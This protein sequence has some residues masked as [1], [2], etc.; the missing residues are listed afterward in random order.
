M[1]YVL[2]SRKTP[3]FSKCRR[4]HLALSHDT[5]SNSTGIPS[6]C[7]LTF[8]ILAA[9]NRPPRSPSPSLN[10]FVSLNKSS[11]ANVEFSSSSPSSYWNV[12]RESCSF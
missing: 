4:S 3:H 9:S 5:V 8:S 12:W 10:K 2:N 1:D 7:N 11:F 6:P